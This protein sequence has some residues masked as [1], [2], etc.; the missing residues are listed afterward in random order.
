VR[1]VRSWPA[2]VPGHHPRVVDGLERVITDGPDYRPLAGIDDD[3]IHLDWDMAVCPEDLAHFA[4]HAREDPG[5]V[6]VGPYRMYAGSL[7]GA[8]PRGLAADE[9]AMRRYCAGP[10]G[11]ETAMRHI[12][13]GDGACHLFGFGM[14]YFP[15]GLLAKFC[16]A[17]PGEPLTDIGWSGWHNRNVSYEARLCWH[18]HPVHLNF[19]PPSL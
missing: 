17:F 2:D 10:A 5:A 6:L 15:A 19:P 8:R 12:T 14:V 3:L 11:A 7:Q 9:W 13:P 18:V 16:A 4:A 1:L